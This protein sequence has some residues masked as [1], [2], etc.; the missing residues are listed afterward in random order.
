MT[1]PGPDWAADIYGEFRDLS[2]D[3]AGDDHLFIRNK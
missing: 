3:L 2:T 1:C